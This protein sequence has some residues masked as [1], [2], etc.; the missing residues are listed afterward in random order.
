MAAISSKKAYSLH[1]PP[2]DKA[3]GESKTYTPPHGME[4]GASPN[5]HI[6]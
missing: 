6:A 2:Q 1:S 5:E 4:V 3:L